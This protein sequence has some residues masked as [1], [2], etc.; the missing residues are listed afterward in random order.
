MTDKMTKR[1]IEVRVQNIIDLDK[2]KNK[3][4]AMKTK[5]LNSKLQHHGESS[6]YGV[7]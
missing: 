4:L 6:G 2:A 3:Q 1:L 7:H 5:G